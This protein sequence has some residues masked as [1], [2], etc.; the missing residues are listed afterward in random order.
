[1]DFSMELELIF[2]KNMK[3]IQNIL[4]FL[5]IVIISSNCSSPLDVPANRNIKFT[6]DNYENPYV[7]LSTNY[8]NYD[9]IHPDSIVVKT[10]F[11]QNKLQ[12][13]Y[14]ISNYNLYFGDNN[15]KI[16][17]KTTPILLAAIGENGWEIPIEI[18][19]QAKSPGVFI[20]TL[21]FANLE[22]TFCMVEAKVPY[23]FANDYAT[24]DFKILQKNEF[25]VNFKNMS[26]FSSTIN[27]VKLDD[28]TKITLKTGLPITINRNSNTML[29]FE[30]FSDVPEV[31]AVNIKFSLITE[32]NRSLVDS[33]CK[34]KIISK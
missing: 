2:K 20:D 12:H 33:T 11:I 31:V 8:L 28:N 15:F 4:F 9:F 24:D 30:Y 19:F 6:E 18:Q 10:V 32:A 25:S 7:K 27:E 26:E 17:N 29:T 23:I 14:L 21:V 34:I 16:L 1:M 5:I 13:N 22:Y 3:K